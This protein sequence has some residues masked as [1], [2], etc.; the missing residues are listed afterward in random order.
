MRAV[1]T[2]YNKE[3]IPTSKANEPIPISFS[4][5]TSVSETI[6]EPKQEQKKETIKP[7]LDSARYI[8]KGKHQYKTSDIDP[9]NMKEFLDLAESEGVSFRITSG[10]RKNATTSSGNVSNHAIGNAVDITPLDGQSWD[11]LIQAI[12]SSPKLLA[13]M[14]DKK[15]R[16]LDERSPEMLTKTGGTGAH[17]HISFGKTEGKSADEFFV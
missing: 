4:N 14:K 2:S 12:K 13:Y 5:Y 7:I 11:E 6:S 8:I 16:I 15:M 1:Y 9:G 17:F 10:T 3:Q